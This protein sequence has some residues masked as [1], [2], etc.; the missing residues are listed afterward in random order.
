MKTL[1]QSLIDYDMA[2]LKA[3]AECRAIAISPL[4]QAE[5]VKQ[6]TE[7]LLSPATIAITLTDLTEAE[8]EALQFLWQYKGQAESGRFSQQFGTIRPMGAARLERERP[9]QT[10]EN[11]AE[12]LWYKGFIYKAFQVTDHGS[13]EMVYIPKDLLP[14]LKLHHLEPATDIFTMP[15]LPSPP[16]IINVEG[17]WREN[18]F[19]LLVSLQ[20]KVIRWP[21]TKGEELDDL[22]AGLLSPLAVTLPTQIEIPFL[23]HLAK[24]AELIRVQQGQLKPNREVVKLWLQADEKQQ[25]QFFQH[26]WRTDGTWNDLAHVGGLVPPTVGWQNDPVATRA[27]ILGH[28]AKLTPGHWVSLDDFVTTIRRFDPNFQRPD[29]DYNSW[30][31]QHEHGDFLMGFAN[32]ERVEGQLLRYQITHLLAWLGVVDLGVASPKDKPQSFRVTPSGQLFLSNLTATPPP[33]FSWRNAEK[34]DV[35]LRVGTNFQVHVPAKCNL[36]DRFQLARCANLDRRG[37]DQTSYYLTPV[38]I[39]RALQNGITIEQIT[40]FLTRASHQQVP[41]QVLETLQTWAARQGSARLEQVFL[42]HLKTPDVVHE[43]RQH[44]MLAPLLGET[45]SPT[46]ILVAAQYAPQVQ[47]LLTELGYVR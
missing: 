24:Q 2:L 20:T 23:L 34:V 43:L 21:L 11:G 46:T 26:L 14:L 16:T 40:A 36:Y 3:I 22:A 29:G 47:R 38:S 28:L 10:P 12:G 15:S 27:K 44:A 45:I 30:Y 18:I 31:I 4:N 33:I 35:P 25:I 1:Y 17:R 8:L 5:A 37:H 42:L 9:W 41:H 13:V 39:S 32:W 6:L 19:S 7:T